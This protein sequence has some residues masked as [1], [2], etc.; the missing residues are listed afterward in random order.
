MPPRRPQLPLPLDAL[1][2]TAPGLEPL[3]LAELSAL[4]IRATTEETGA[5]SAA[6]SLRDLYRA[7]LHLRTA[8]R[9][10]VRLAQFKALTFADVE[11]HA[12]RVPWG[13][14]VTAGQRVRFRVTCRK[15]RLYHSDA[16]AERL[17]DALA[18]TVPGVMEAGGAADDDE[19]GGDA[20]LFVVRV[21]RDRLLLSVDASGALLHRRGYR[22]AVA[23]APLRETLAAAMLFGAGWRGD[24]PLVDP[25]CGSGTIAIEAALL[26]RRIAPG[27]HRTFAFEQWP[28]HDAMLWRALVWEAQSDVLPSS[29][30]AIVATDRDAGAIVATRANAE[31][32][33]VLADLTVAQ[34]SLSDLTT[35]PGPGTIVL[36]PPYGVRV[37]EKAPLRN[38]FAQL[39]NVLRAQA[40]GW[41]LAMLSADRDLERQMKIPL[42]ERWKS[43]NGG[44]PVRLVTAEV[45]SY[46]R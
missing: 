35:P 24:T 27:L 23:K 10:V 44:I 4:G 29:P 32:A 42:T 38:L 11:K 5:V 18:L 20:Q 33:G 30:V 17:M 31:R 40:G 34:Q 7:N 45:K 6:L 22:Q 25:M 36:N 46:G 14:V 41:T 2:V 26:A 21:V 3:A 43:S 15:S 13:S 19:E 1:I 39:G 9:V 12:R 16:V 28:G 37:G 8:S